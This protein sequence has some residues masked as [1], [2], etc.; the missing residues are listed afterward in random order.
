MSEEP[1]RA[2]EYRKYLMEIG[3]KEKEKF[4]PKHFDLILEKL[5]SDRIDM[6][7]MVAKF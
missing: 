5:E 7:Q 6:L 3:T 1:K 2:T 4:F